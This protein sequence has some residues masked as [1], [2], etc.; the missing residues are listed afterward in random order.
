M[1][2]KWGEW[3]RRDIL[4]MYGPWLPST[5]VSAIRSKPI[6]EIFIILPA[7]EYQKHFDAYSSHFFAAPMTALLGPGKSISTC[8]AFVAPAIDNLARKIYIKESTSTGFGT[9][10]HEFVHYLQHYDFYPEFYCLGGQN[11]FLLEGVT[12]YVT[13]RTRSEVFKD[14]QQRGNYQSHYDKIKGWIGASQSRHDAMMKLNFQGVKCKDLETLG[15]VYP[16]TA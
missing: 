3:A 11:P 4:H 14:R 2:I 6:R 1:D 8:P 5:L 16:L 13:R 9:F 7:T 10:Y 15:G 12:E